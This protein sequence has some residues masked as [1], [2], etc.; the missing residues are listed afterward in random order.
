MA[1]AQSNLGVFRFDGAPREAAVVFT[2]AAKAG[3]LEAL[4]NR[5]IVQ[6]LMRDWASADATLLDMGKRTEVPLSLMVEAD[7]GSAV[8]GASHV[9]ARYKVAGAAFRQAT[10]AEPTRAALQKMLGQ[11]LL[12]GGR[13]AE[14]ID[15]LKRYVAAASPDKDDSVWSILEAAKTAKALIKATEHTEEK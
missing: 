1:A 5:A 7:F 2:A 10:R 14:P 15:H 6:L 12:S 4:F 9:Q 3:N 11:S 13:A 8:G